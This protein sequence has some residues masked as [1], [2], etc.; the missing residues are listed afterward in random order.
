M[1][2]VVPNIGRVAASA[3]LVVLFSCAGHAGRRI[4]PNYDPTV[5]SGDQLANAHY[6]TL[7]DMIEALRPNWLKARGRD[8]IYNP[9]SVLVYLDDNKFGEVGTLRSINPTSVRYV[10]FLDG[11]AASARWGVGHGSGVIL[12]VSQ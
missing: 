2:N 7:Y 11:L 10:H 4:D 8:S 6:L 3:L 1:F 5:L 12:V 9:T